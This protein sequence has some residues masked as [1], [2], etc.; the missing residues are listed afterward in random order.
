MCQEQVSAEGILHLVV[1]PN[2]GSNSGMRIFEP[3]ILGPNS[4]VEFFGPMFSN[5]RT[6]S[7][8]PGRKIHIAL[9]QCHFAEELLWR[10][11]LKCLPGFED[12]PWY[13]I[14]KFQRTVWGGGGWK[15][16]WETTSRMTPHPCLLRFPRLG[17]VARFSCSKS[18][19][20]IFIAERQNFK[21]A[22]FQHFCCISLL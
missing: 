18:L 6:L 2:L 20:P 22:Q 7:R 5:K 9:L 19:V 15:K 3:C 11:H 17:V 21:D 14:Q 8:I 10:A 16:R 4:G 13:R 12:L 1:N